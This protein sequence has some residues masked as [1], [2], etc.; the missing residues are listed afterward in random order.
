MGDIE[1][2]ICCVTFN[3]A[4]Y[5]RK[6]LDTLVCQE[7]NFKYEI[8]IHDDL[9]QDGTIGII[10]EYAKKYPDIIVPYIEEENQ[11][12]K[13][14]RAIIINLMLG[15]ARGKYIAICEGDDFWNDEKKLQKQYD[16][17]EQNS[18]CVMCTHKVRTVDETGQQIIAYIPKD[19]NE[20]KVIN[21]DWYVKH[22]LE[23]D[24]HLFH[25]SSMFFRKSAMEKDFGNIP[26][27]MTVAAT[28]DRVLFLY[29]GSKGNLIYLPDEMSSYRS[30]SEGSWS[31]KMVKYRD[32]F[33]ANDQ[34]ILEMIDGFNKYTN[35][36]YKDSVYAYETIVKFRTLQ[37]ELNCK[38]LCS[39]RYEELFQTLSKKE[40][41]YF[42]ICSKIPLLGKSYRKLKK[43]IKRQ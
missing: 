21:G 30:M 43:L 22:I 16:L 40:Q 8:L 24:R 15:L 14:N 38:E 25:T 11:Y 26:P 2:T 23:N 39:K 28:E 27:F 17:L 9:S 32:R 12:S 5:V 37:Y 35:Y 31:S 29:Y 33:Y 3:H 20:K 18:D 10:Q 19:Y 6:C 4:K 13:G 1:V 42:R 7:T 41:I 34:D 36:K